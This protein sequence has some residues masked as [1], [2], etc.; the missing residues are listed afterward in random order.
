MTEPLTRDAGV[1]N[2]QAALPAPSSPK[3]NHDAQDDAQPMSRPDLPD[4]PFQ[5]P[6]SSPHPSP[7]PSRSLSRSRDPAQDES[8]RRRSTARPRAIKSGRVPPAE[9]RPRE[10]PFAHMPV[11]FDDFAIQLRQ[12]KYKE[13][14]KHILS[15][16]RRQLAKAIALSARLHRV[17]SWVRAGLVEISTNTDAAGF[18]RVRQ[19]MHDLIDSC[20][21]QWSHEI[22]VDVLSTAPHRDKPSFWSKLPDSSQQDCLEL[23]DHLRRK[24]QFLV[25]RFKAMGP[26]QIKGLAL[27][28]TPKYHKVSDS[29]LSS[30]P[31]TR[32]RSPRSSR[33]TSYSKQL[34]EFASSF[35]RSNPL[36][37]LLHNVYGPSLN[38]RDRESRLRIST[39]SSVCAQLMTEAEAIYRPMFGRILSTFP[40]LYDWHIKQRLELLLMKILQQGAMFLDAVS[41]DKVHFGNNSALNT[42]DARDFLDESVRSLFALLALDD[43]IPSGALEFGRAI[44][45]K[46]PS[47]QARTRFRGDFLSSWFLRDFLHIAI[48]YPEDEGMLLQAHISTKCRHNLLYRVYEHAFNRANDLYNPM[49]LQPIDP[50]VHFYFEEMVDKLSKPGE[51][52]D[53]YVSDM[54]NSPSTSSPV[55]TS[56]SICAADISHLLEGLSPQFIHTSSPWNSFLSASHSTFRT[57]YRDSKYDKLLQAILSVIEP[58]QS[59]KNVHVCEE[60]WATLDISITGRLVAPQVPFITESQTAWSSFG[61]LDPV[62]H[63][64]IRLV[65]AENEYRP[66]L[67]SKITANESSLHEMFLKQANLARVKADGVTSFYWHEAYQ[68]LQREYPM[69]VLSTD[70]TKIL[71]PLIQK[72]K[73]LQREVIDTCARLDHELA[74]LESI[75]AT[76]RARLTEVVS[77]I[78]KLRI[79]LWYTLNILTS[80]VYEGARNVSMG[81]KNMRAP[82]HPGAGP[83]NLG[84]SAYGTS[85]SSMSSAS[86]SSHLDQHQIDTTMILKAPK[87]HGGPQKLSD[88]QIEATKKWLK[89]VENFCKGEER[90]HRFC[91]EVTYAMRKLVGETLSDSPVLWSSELFA[92][93]KNLYEAHSSSFLSPSTRPPSVMSEPVSSSLLVPRFGLQ[94]SRGSFYSQSSNK[95]GRPS[96]GSDLSSLISS[97]GRAPT[98]TTT[99]SH[100]LW[101]PAPSNRKS[102]TSMSS[103]SNFGTSFETR[104]AD[105]ILE[106]MAFL[107]DIQQDLTSL[108]LSDLGCLVWNKG[109]ET[110]LWMNM[111]SLWPGVGQSVK[112]RDVMAR[113]LSKDEAKPAR[114]G[115]QRQRS[116]SASQGPPDLFEMD[117]IE[118]AL[119]EEPEGTVQGAFTFRNAFKDILARI[120]HHVNPTMKL[121]AVDDFA[122][123][124]QV[125]RKSVPKAQDR[126]LE[127][128]DDVNRRC[129]LNPSLLSASLLRHE[130]KSKI[131]STAS[132]TATNDEAESVHVLKKIMFT[133]A[134]KTIFRDLQYISGFVASPTLESSGVAKSFL[135]VGLAA[136]AWKD[137]VCRGLI[138]IADGLAG[139]ESPNESKPGG[140]P[141]GPGT[142]V[143]N[144]ADLWMIAAREGHAVAQR[145]LAILYLTHAEEMP[146]VSMPW[147][148]AADIFKPDMIWDQDAEPQQLHQPDQPQSQSQHRRQA[149]YLALHWMQVAADNGDVVAQKRLEERRAGRSIP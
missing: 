131:P 134:P 120:S 110:D 81:L 34:E 145:E 77:Q 143:I 51:F 71:S 75:Y 36:P 142:S 32:G 18:A 123:L 126:G 57:Q 132:A 60:D 116:H 87:K 112:K 70:D 95:T 149:L 130:Q 54:T 102:N 133:L 40:S 147:A 7:R 52:T 94:G 79:K 6:R 58:G 53:P 4:H 138:D 12:L 9:T 136:L 29:V 65:D 104:S 72:T 13:Q 140:K 17:C 93:E 125:F 85:R 56:L 66:P 22:Q 144:A 96:L 68:C 31:S 73:T 127:M 25:D 122:V 64:A 84:G 109:S 113:L 55:L 100:Q 91:M 63:A 111:V 117:P 103:R 42:Q 28:A 14:K 74:D 97:P 2:A 19:H 3:L 82:P 101:S 61:S 78:D 107:A 88:Q 146:I 27:S 33:L 137:E 37:F 35:E 47:E 11:S 76:S 83:E 5:G 119:A 23:L 80:D 115:E 90:I 15:H 16:Q 148:L 46:L 89:R 67:T 129:S 39:W 69:A 43:G 98:V 26:A 92:R 105:R 41:E 114:A 62:E 118:R 50:A 106:K 141:P 139:R 124:A 99:D 38:L 59:S 44:I 30:L 86:I 8:A 128:E 21:S 48:V 24:P 45:S 135:H 108:L 1:V 10:L 20:S 121:K 49:R